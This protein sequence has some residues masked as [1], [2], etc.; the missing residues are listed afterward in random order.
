G[1]FIN[2]SQMV[3]CIGQQAING[4]RVVDGFD[5]RTLPHFTLNSKTPS[6]KG[7]VG[8]SFFSGQAPHELFFHTMAGREGLI[9]TAVKTAT[10]GYMNRRLSKCMED[11]SI[12]YDSTVREVGEQIVQFKYGDDGLDPM[13]MESS[14]HSTVIDL[15]EVL[16]HAKSMLVIDYND[17]YLDDSSKALDIFRY[18]KDREFSNL[19]NHPFIEKVEYFKTKNIYIF[20]NFIRDKINLV[21]DTMNKL[22]ITNSLLGI[23]NDQLEI[24]SR[25]VFEKLQ[26]A[27]V[28][29]GTAVGVLCSQSIG[30]PATQM[31][32]KTFHFAGVASMNITQ[33]VP[34]LTEI[35]NAAQKLSTPIINVELKESENQQVAR[36]VK[37]RLEKTLLGEIS[38]YI[39][40][41]LLPDEC[42]LLI[43][44]SLA[45]IKLLCL[46]IDI[47]DIVNCILKSKLKIMP[48]QISIYSEDLFC[49]KPQAHGL[50]LESDL[51]LYHSKLP[52]VVV[53]GLKTVN[54]AVLMED[55]KNNGHY[56]LILDG[57]GLREVFSIPEVCAEKTTS[58]NIIEIESV[59]GVEAG[60]SAIINELKATMDNHGIQIDTR[61]HLMIA[62]AMSC[63]GKIYGMT[64]FGLSYL[65]Q[66]VFMLASFE[67][68]CDH[69]F[70]AAYHGQ[71]DKINGV[72][73]SIIMGKP[74][75]LGTGCF[76]LFFQ[77]KD[78][79]VDEFDLETKTPMIKDNKKFG[80]K[81]LQSC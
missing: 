5:N 43:K 44:I 73:D 12:H 4:K 77:H 64:R 63:Q 1:S 45:R 49:V 3:A 28:E 66:S 39:E 51:F 22:F 53:S 29:P 26:R 56:K 19:Q 76:D 30:E 42:Y 37:S 2:I 48:S 68:T 74:I 46:K 70:E 41:V 79:L 59:L 36:I 6:A 20:R 24:F 80:L 25:M 60:R 62:D 47:Y 21:K 52:Q 58:N 61:H 10:T 14:K 9:D 17:K 15:E 75:S 54:K 13:H 69:L 31:T 71:S 11:L 81:R 23:S 50:S 33:G 16:L 65:K 72:S 35:I 38:E 27:I 34:R 32:L 18:I 55:E 40:E 67:K 57:S 78:E 8:N 7:F